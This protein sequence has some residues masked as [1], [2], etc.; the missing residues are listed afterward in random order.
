[1]TLADLLCQI[2]HIIPPQSPSTAQHIAA[3]GAQVLHNSC[4]AALTLLSVSNRLPQQDSKAVQVTCDPHH[5]LECLE[6]ALAYSDVAQDKV[7]G[8]PGF[9]VFLRTV[10]PC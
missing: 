10:S 3:H 6:H 8:I 7:D 5:V 2:F 1:M 9:E 4:S